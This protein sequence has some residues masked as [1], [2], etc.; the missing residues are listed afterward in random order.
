V[1]DKTLL[2]QEAAAAGG[3]KIVDAATVAQ[4]RTP[5]LIKEIH[6]YCAAKPWGTDDA[7]QAF[8][9]GFNSVPG[10]LDQ[11]KKNADAIGVLGHNVQLGVG[12]TVDTD[13]A[14]RDRIVATGITSGKPM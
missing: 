9:K 5:D 14:S 12:K 3:K 11:V 8:E 6:G 13:T 1:S 4:Q 2:D 7:G 10:A